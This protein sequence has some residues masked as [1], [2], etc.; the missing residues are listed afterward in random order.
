MKGGARSNA[1]RK[2][3]K[4]KKIQVNVWIET[5]IINKHGGLEAVKELIKKQIS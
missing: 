3:A 1:G 2:P 4:D 5:S